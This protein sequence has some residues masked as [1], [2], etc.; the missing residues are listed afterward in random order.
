MNENRMKTSVNTD[1]VSLSPAQTA[2][3]GLKIGVENG[4]GS[5]KQGWVD[6]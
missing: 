2:G 3:W 1:E 4:C 6:E 5:E